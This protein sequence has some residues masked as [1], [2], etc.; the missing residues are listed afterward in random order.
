MIM[1]IFLH[2]LNNRILNKHKGI[3]YERNT[4]G[5]LIISILLYVSKMDS[6]SMDGKS[7]DGIVEDICKKYKLV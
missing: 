3:L 7:L 1:T 4:G 6:I 5:F 2:I